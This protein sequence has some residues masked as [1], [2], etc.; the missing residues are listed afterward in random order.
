MQG[1]CCPDSGS[2]GFKET[3]IKGNG[4]IEYSFDRAASSNLVVKY[5]NSGTGNACASA[6]C[7]CFCRSFLIT[8]PGRRVHRMARNPHFTCWALVGNSV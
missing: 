6:V 5:V 4:A 3:P 2:S 7:Q 8:S 1:E